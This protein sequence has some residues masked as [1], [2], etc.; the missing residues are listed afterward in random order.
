MSAVHLKY[1]RQD[2]LPHI[3]CP[4]CGNGIIM[5]AF[6]RAVDELEYDQNEIVVVS[7]IGCSGRISGYLDFHTLHTTHGRALAFA[8]GI[9]M[10]E[11]RLKIFVFMGDGDAAAIGGNHL[12]HACRRNIDLT[13]IVI[14]NSVFGMTGGQFSPMTEKDHQASTA[15]YG[16]IERN[17]D[18]C[19]LSQV[20]GATFVARTGIY[21]VKQLIKLMVQGAQHKGFALIEVIS[22]CPVNFGRRNQMGSP[23]DMLKWQKEL[24]SK[25]AANEDS[26]N[27]GLKFGLL[28]QAQDPEYVEEYQKLVQRVRKD[29]KP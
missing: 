5:G 18:I 13:A 28:Y 16:N 29:E 9:K 27:T 21:Q 25:N 10:A 19:S 11:P 4:G 22:Q 20:A 17:F 26:T 23:V 1:L 3:W 8:T 24:I 7:G 6:V 2:N 15:P 14:N 12:I